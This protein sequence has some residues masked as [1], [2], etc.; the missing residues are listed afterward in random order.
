MIAN[1]N[2]KKPGF[3]ASLSKSVG[4]PQKSRNVEGFFEKTNVFGAKI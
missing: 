2:L 1:N 4:T 3:Q